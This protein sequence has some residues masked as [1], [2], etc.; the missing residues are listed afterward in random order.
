MNGKEAADPAVVITLGP[1]ADV[2]AIL[3]LPV[4]GALQ[5]PHGITPPPVPLQQGKM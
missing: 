2:H 3:G 5:F 4:V 1:V